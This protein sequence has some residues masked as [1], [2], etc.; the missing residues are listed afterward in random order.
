[1]AEI[2]LN[3]ALM[4]R[5]T[6]RDFSDKAISLQALQRLLWAAQG[7]SGDDGKRTAPSAHALHPLRLLVVVNNVTALEKGLYAVDGVDGSLT[8]LHLLDLRNS[9]RKASIGDPEWVTDAACIVVICADMVAATQAFAGQKP[10]GQRGARYAYLEA[11][12]AAQNLQLQAVAED[13]GSVWVGGF[14][15]EA[16][17][18]VLGLQAP[19]S[20]IILLCIGHPQTPGSAK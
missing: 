13:L 8:P 19:V 20:P 3:R 4:H 14:D 5:R 18:N 7:I 2:S 15:D 6:V 12:A 10:Y 16:T 1:L 11:G 17:D 9:L